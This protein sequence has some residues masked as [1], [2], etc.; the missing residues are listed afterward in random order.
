[1]N[2]K[3]RH[4]Q[5][6]HR[7]WDTLARFWVH[8]SVRRLGDRQPGKQTADWLSAHGAVSWFAFV[9]QR[10]TQSSRRRHAKE[11]T[12][13]QPAV[14]NGREKERAASSE[15]ERQVAV[16]RREAVQVAASGQCASSSVVLLLAAAA[17]SS[18]SPS[19]VADAA[20]TAQLRLELI[21][22]DRSAA[23]ECAPH[24]RN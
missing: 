19:L 5:L 8:I 15:G 24:S 1:M 22:A 4:A 17:S 2:G 23:M 7:R 12:A 10:E 16:W 9:E 6:L 20:V 3:Q 11:Q 21:E 18:T 14:C 13:S